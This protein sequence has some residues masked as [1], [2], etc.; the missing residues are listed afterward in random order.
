MNRLSFIRNTLTVG[1]GLLLG[2]GKW[3]LSS[4]PLQEIRDIPGIDRAKA[5]I[6]HIC[7]AGPIKFWSPFVTNERVGNTRLV[8]DW[9]F[10]YKIGTSDY[11]G[12]MIFLAPVNKW[13]DTDPCYITAFEPGIEN[14]CVRFA[15]SMAVYLKDDIIL[16]DDNTLYGPKYYSNELVQWLKMPSEYR[17]A[18]PTSFARMTKRV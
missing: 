13:E 1:T 2:A 4:D 3:A 14:V 17:W 8:E 10:R 6:K 5:Y 18:N 7:K 15:Q 11:L 16:A 9:A 12:D